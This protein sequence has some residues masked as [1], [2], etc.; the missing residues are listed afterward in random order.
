VCTVEP[1]QEG[2]VVCDQSSKKWKLVELLWQTEFDLTYAG[3]IF[4]Y[5]PLRSTL[6]EFGSMYPSEHHHFIIFAQMVKTK[7]TAMQ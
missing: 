1:V 3:E 6:L 7:I 4:D 2:L 5:Q